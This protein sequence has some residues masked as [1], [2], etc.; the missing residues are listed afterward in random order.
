M[1]KK[2]LIFLTVL[3]LLVSSLLLTACDGMDRINVAVDPDKGEGT[4]DI[5][6]GGDD[7]GDSGGDDGGDTQDG[8]SAGDGDVD[9]SDVQ[10][11]IVF[12]TVVALLLGVT[13]IVVSLSN[14]PRNQ[15]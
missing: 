14:R 10:T 2:R 8:S 3:T 7:G 15:S 6:G 13:A 9:E 5:A 4:I 11:A 1:I 12:A